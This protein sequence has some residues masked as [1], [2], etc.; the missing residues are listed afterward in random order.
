M[1]RGHRRMARCECTGTCV[2]FG[3]WT[4]VTA[5]CEGLGLEFRSFLSL[6]S[7]PSRRRAQ[8]WVIILSLRRGSSRLLRL[9]GLNDVGRRYD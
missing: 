3:P 6:L 8:A 4:S 2:R 9:R 1:P 7:Y 5:P